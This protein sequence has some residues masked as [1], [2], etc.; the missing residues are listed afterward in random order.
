MKWS[1]ATEVGRVRSQNEDCVLAAADIGLFAVADGMG[2]HRA[3]EVASHMALQDLERY[4]RK[5]LN[6][7]MGRIL[8]EAVKN[9]NSNVFSSSG[10][11]PSLKGMGT[12]LTAA[13]IKGGCAVICHV[14]D[15][16]AYLIRKGKMSQL[17]LDHSLVQELFD[18]GGI[19]RAQAREHPHRNVL[20]RALGA[21]PVVDVDLITLE[22]K[23][24]DV[25]LLCTDGLTGLLED[26]EIFNIL[27]QSRGLDDA[28]GKLVRTALDRGGYDNISLVLIEL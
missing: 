21:E 16:R 1:Q 18:V 15:S 9:A 10:G 12:T 25:L 17:T 3:G 7:E 11:E 2:G 13:V 20:T 5:N 19:T 8:T 23:P 27:D 22:L 4:I 26:G 28:V 14:G 6:G 24:G